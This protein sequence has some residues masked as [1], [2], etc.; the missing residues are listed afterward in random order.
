MEKYHFLMKRILKPNN[1]H[2]VT[3]KLIEKANL[4]AGSSVFSWGIM[5]RPLNDGV[6]QSAKFTILY[7]LTAFCL[8]I[9]NSCKW[10]IFLFISQDSLTAN[11]LGDRTYVYGPRLLIKKLSG[12]P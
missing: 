5:Y 9:F 11:L 8:I 12:L 4:N 6:I 7:W 10:K 1:F 2:F 3:N